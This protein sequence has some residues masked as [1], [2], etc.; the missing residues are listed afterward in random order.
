M[1]ISSH[2]TI[3]TFY[4]FLKKRLNGCLCE[5]WLGVGEV[6]YLGV[7]GGPCVR[8]YANIVL[9]LNEEMP[10]GCVVLRPSL[11]LL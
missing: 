10:R 3:D 11:S 6:D 2:L 7:L 9:V 8:V 4:K 5:S 1:K